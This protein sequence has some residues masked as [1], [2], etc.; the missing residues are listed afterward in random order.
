MISNGIIKGNETHF[1]KLHDAEGSSHLAIEAISN[2]LSGR[3]FF[4]PATLSN[5][6][7]A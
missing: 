6:K 2:K 3:T 4:A 1:I 5:P 7:A